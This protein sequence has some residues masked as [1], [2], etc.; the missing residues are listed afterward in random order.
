MQTHAQISLKPFVITY[1]AEV[2]GQTLTGIQ[3]V[4]LLDQNQYEFSFRAKSSGIRLNE[5]TVFTVD[6]NVIQPLSYENKRKIVLYNRNTSVNFDWQNKIAE[7]KYKGRVNQ[8]P[9]ETENLHSRLS[10]QLQMQL[11]AATQKT[12][13]EYDLVSRDKLR[14]YVFDR[15]A[16]EVVDTPLG[17]FDSIVF[18]R[19]FDD[20]NKSSKIWLAR[21]FNNI[22][23]KLDQRVGDESTSLLIKSAE[24]DGIPVKGNQ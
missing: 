9:I 2:R 23:V 3:E 16:D 18:T 19:R 21:Q 13:L 8:L 24:I 1:Q 15:L 12:P 10:Y 22:I 6:N 11:D 17:K 5:N 14:H 4:K 7:T 20:K